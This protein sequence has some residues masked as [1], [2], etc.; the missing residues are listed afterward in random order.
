MK[1][2]ISR[3]GHAFT[4]Y[5][6]IAAV[7]IAPKVLGFD[8]EPKAVLMTRV[9]T[10]TILISS[11]FTRAEWGF[12]RVMPLKIHLLLDLL[13]GLTALGAPWALGFSNNARARNAFLLIGLFGVLAGTLTRDEEMK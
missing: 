6:Y 12:I 4:D 3:A 2:P 8:D 13:G 7:S 5:P 9:L 1:K 10:S 11:I